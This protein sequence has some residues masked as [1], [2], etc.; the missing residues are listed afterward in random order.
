MRGKVSYRLTPTSQV[1]VAGGYQDQRDIDY[2]G[3]L[4]DAD[5][6]EAADV[7]ARYELSQ[8]GKVFRSL[9]ALVYW[10]RVDHGMDNDEKPTRD[11]GMF[12]NGNPRP[13][14]IITVDSEMQNIGGRLAAEIVPDDHWT[15]TVG[16]DVYSTASRAVL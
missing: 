16:G 4:L 9:D 1:T 3:R 8:P 15:L 2:P 10:H 6:F 13:P 5:F 7:S 12:P 11:A 14:L